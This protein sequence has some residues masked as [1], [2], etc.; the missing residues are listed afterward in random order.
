MPK[1]RQWWQNDDGVRLYVAGYGISGGY[2]VLNHPKAVF[3]VV[4]SEPV[5]WRLGWRHLPGCDSFSWE[6]PNFPPTESLQEVPTEQEHIDS[7]VDELEQK[8]ID[9]ATAIQTKLEADVAAGESFPQ[10]W[11]VLSGDGGA[12]V[13]R[14]TPD[15]YVLV[16]KDGTDSPVRPWRSADAKFRRLLTEAEAM[17]LLD[18]PV[19]AEPIAAVTVEE[20]FPSNQQLFEAV[21]NLR[22]QMDRMNKRFVNQGYYA[23]ACISLRVPGSRDPVVDDLIRAAVR[24]DIAV[25]FAAGCLGRS[26]RHDVTQLADLPNAAVAFADDMLKKLGFTE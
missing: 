17:A 14:M 2:V 6:E 10:Y 18:K 21:A 25:S 12:Y 1:P 15:Y 9:D 3:S 23:E 16:R 22:D 19:A 5:F 26:D 24:R 8:R 13:F 4:T 11:T 7:L 20:P